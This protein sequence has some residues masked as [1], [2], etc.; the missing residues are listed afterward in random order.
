MPPAKAASKSQDERN[1]AEAQYFKALTKKVAAEAWQA[2][3][4]A[5]EFEEMAADARSANK[6]NRLYEFT[7]AVERQSVA[8]AIDQISRWARLD[9]ERPI[10]IRF[11]SPGG[12]VIYGLSLYD[13]LKSVDAEGTPVTTV[14]MGMAAS[15]AGTLLQAGRRRVVTPNSY[16]MIHEITGGTEGS[17]SEMEDN[18]KLMKR[19]NDR[20]MI[21]LAE[22]SKMTVAKIKQ[23]ANR[24]DFWVDAQQAVEL[25]FAD[26]IGYR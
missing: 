19:L 21:I 26:E 25:G 17:A 4:E 20:L 7:S 15:M 18:T 1:Y 11:N 2:E 6:R 12:D 13:F 16:F 8:A 10:T 3:V 22:R 23:A 14:A 24:K 5:S 9:P